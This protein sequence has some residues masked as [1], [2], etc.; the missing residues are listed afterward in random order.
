MKL[1]VSTHILPDVEQLATHALVLNVGRVAAMG[2]L[3]ELRASETKAYYVRVNGTPEQLT[4][5][6]SAQGVKWERQHPNIRVDL[7]DARAVLRHVREAGLAVRHLTPVTLS[8]EEAFEQAVA[9]S[10]GGAPDVV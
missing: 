6:L 1:L 4:A 3:D 7:D 5:H 9:R 2:T 8:L 10:T